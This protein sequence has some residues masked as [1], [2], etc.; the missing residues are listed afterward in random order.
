MRDASGAFWAMAHSGGA[1]AAAEHFR[2]GMPVIDIAA[3]I[4]RKPSTVSGYL[5]EWIQSE[6]PESVAPWVP[7]ALYER[8][9]AAARELNID[10]LGPIK[11]HLEADGSAEVP[12]DQIRIVMTHRRTRAT[13]S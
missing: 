2:R 9:D 13:N 7:P 10:R 3:A 12:F 1:E 8:I 6:R 5:T 11:Q 4:G